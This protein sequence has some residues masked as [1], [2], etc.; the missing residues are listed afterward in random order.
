MVSRRLRAR[1]YCPECGQECYM[2]SNMRFYDCD[3]VIQGETV[4]GKVFMKR[5][6]T[7]R[8]LPR[9]DES[10]HTFVSNQVTRIP[11]LVKKKDIL[12]LSKI[13]YTVD[14][15]GKSFNNLPP[16]TWRNPD[17]DLEFEEFQYLLSL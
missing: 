13:M 11:Q 8:L 1:Q 10:F 7:G 4:T 17:N 15:K 16:G 14:P 2:F 9:E 6:T 12:E 3:F 5:G